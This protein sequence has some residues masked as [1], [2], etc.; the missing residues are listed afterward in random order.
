VSSETQRRPLIERTTRLLNALA[1]GP[2]VVQRCASIPILVDTAASSSRR[3]SMLSGAALLPLA[4]PYPNSSS[5]GRAGLAADEPC[6]H[7]RVS[8]AHGGTSG[9]TLQGASGRLLIQSPEVYTIS[10][11]GRAEAARKSAMDALVFIVVVVLVTVDRTSRYN[12][13]VPIFHQNGKPG[14]Y[15]RQEREHMKETNKTLKV[16][17]HRLAILLLL[18]KVR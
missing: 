11:E 13:H 10:Q 1:C 18:L 12:D 3:L 4:L 5:A 6:K 16:A 14:K 8:M 2:S 17:S 9:R 7:P 15:C